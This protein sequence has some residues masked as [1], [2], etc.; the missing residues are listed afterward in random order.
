M[1]DPAEHGRATVIAAQVAAAQA[2]DGRT[3]PELIDAYE[4]GPAVLADTLVGM[5]TEAMRARP[6]EGR[7][8]TLEVLGHT[9]DSE[10]FFADRMK[11]TAAMERPLLM[12]AD[13]WLYPDAL[14]YQDRDPE[15]QMRLIDAT[16]RQMADD[17]RR[18]PA[19]AWERTAV[20]SETGLVTLRQLLLHAIRHL[21]HHVGTI[22]EKRAALGLD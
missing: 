10:Q 21:E 7:M 9:A 20:H 3:A 17:L 5:T 22:R 12:G 1:S 6:I 19:D 2:D 8:S 15:L 18:L 4:A 11:R 16:R 14:A 13:G